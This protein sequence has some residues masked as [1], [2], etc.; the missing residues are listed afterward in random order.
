MAA[1]GAVAAGGV[2]AAGAPVVAGSVTAAGAALVGAGVV[3]PTCVGLAGML[4]CCASAAPLSTP[5]MASPQ[6][7]A[8]KLLFITIMP[9]TSAWQ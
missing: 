9:S 7:Q 4:D 6:N 1:G 8:P 2:T 3:A 5:N